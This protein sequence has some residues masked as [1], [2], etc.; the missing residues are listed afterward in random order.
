MAEEHRKDFTEY[1]DIGPYELHRSGYV[2]VYYQQQ[3]SG[4]LQYKFYIILHLSSIYSAY[5]NLYINNSL[6]AKQSLSY[7]SS[8]Q[9]HTNGDTS[10]TWYTVSAVGTKASFKAE[11]VIPGYTG[12]TITGEVPVPCTGYVDSI[13]VNIGEKTSALFDIHN[14][15]EGYTFKLT[16][17]LGSS[18]T[19]S[20]SF[21]SDSATILVSWVETDVLS[22]LRTSFR[23]SLS[24]SFYT[25]LDG[26]EIGS[27]ASSIY[28]KLKEADA[29]PAVSAVLS[30][31]TEN[32][33]KYGKYVLGQSM[34]HGEV[35]PVLKYGAT[36][37][38]L[39]VQA[40]G[41]FFSDTSFTTATLA[42]MEY[43]TVEITL[44]DS[45]GLT[46]SA[47]LSVDIADWYQPKLTEFSIHRANQDGSAND[48]G[49]YCRI[50][51]SIQVAPV[52]G[53]NSRQ[54]TINQ[55]Q[56]QSKPS[57]T[58]YTQ[59]GSLTVEAS[60]ESSFDIS[61]ELMDDF[62]MTVRTLRLSTAG[63]ALDILKGGKGLGLGKV[64]EVSEAVEL[65]PEWT[66][67]CRALNLDGVDLKQ[68]M[69][70]IDAR[71]KGGGL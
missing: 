11:F 64:A 12:H 6:I 37:R 55:P 23:Y 44:T 30:D 34:L 10:S 36:V 48:S 9:S 45:R 47:S 1:W 66:F 8:L 52:E 2:R 57:L 53:K 63:V 29:E 69:A 40:N 26:E 7:N 3:P 42:S 65:N 67:I 50:D 16:Y 38:S 62:A 33:T 28:F 14:Y 20:R 24:C 32:K 51:W 54:L 68:W 15:R 21:S 17:N 43:K 41:Q 35:T 71:L 61:I 56:G 39:S 5:V 46:A 4:E 31:P 59:N 60:T 22:H 25:Y 58:A 19:Q 18:Y 13:S 49:G 27:S 70:D